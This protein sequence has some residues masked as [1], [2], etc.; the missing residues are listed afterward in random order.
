MLRPQ[1]SRLPLMHDL[2]T[3]LI[4]RIAEAEQHVWLGEVKGLKD[5]LE[6]LRGKTAHA[7]RLVTAGLTDTPATMQ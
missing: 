3:N 7:Q 2:E 6:A 5:T 1:P 4:E